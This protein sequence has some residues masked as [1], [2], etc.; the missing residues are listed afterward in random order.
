[1]SGTQWKRRLA[2]S[3]A[4]CDGEADRPG[5]LV[6]GNPGKDRTGDRPSPAER[7][8]GEAIRDYQRTSGRTFP[9]WSEVL[10]VVQ[11]LGYRKRDQCAE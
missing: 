11:G 1:M 5:A 9:T 4:S 6:V 10:E 2:C 7:E 8:L 3:E